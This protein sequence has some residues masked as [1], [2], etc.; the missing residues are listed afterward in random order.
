MGLKGLGFDK[1]TKRTGV[2]FCFENNVPY[3]PNALICHKSFIVLFWNK[4]VH[5]L[6]MYDV[7]WLRILVMRWHDVHVCMSINIKF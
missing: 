5:G 1:T 2:N 4:M 3:V 6:Y 7:C